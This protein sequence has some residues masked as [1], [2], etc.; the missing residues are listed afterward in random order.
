MIMKQVTNVAMLIIML[1]LII[2]ICGT[3]HLKVSMCFI[4]IN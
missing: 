1:V 2:I 4:N 3:F